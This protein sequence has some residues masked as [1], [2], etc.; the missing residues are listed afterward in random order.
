VVL[1]AGFLIHCF[2]KISMAVDASK[3]FSE[4]RRS[5]LLELVLTTPMNSDEIVRGKILA[6]KRQYMMPMVLVLLIDAILLISGIPYPKTGDFWMLLFAGGC[7]VGFLIADLYVMA[8]AGLWFGLKTNN[9]WRAVRHTVVSVL[10]FPWC[11]WLMCMALLGGV[12][13]GGFGSNVGLLGIGVALVMFATNYVG[14]VGWA[15]SHLNDDF[16]MAVAKM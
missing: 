7:G 11:I 5:G 15:S 2:I 4:D 13:N 3:A 16:R 12:S 9:T 10:V 8:W 1:V 6:L 14:L